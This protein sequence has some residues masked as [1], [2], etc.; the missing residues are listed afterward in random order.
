MYGLVK[1]AA[2]KND[3][4]KQ[5]QEN[6]DDR[7]RA[8]GYVYNAKQNDGYKRN[9]QL[10]GSLGGLAGGAVATPFIAK[11]VN[12]N[13][14]ELVALA[15]MAGFSSGYG[16]GTLFGNATFKKRNQELYDNL[17]QAKRQEFEAGEHIPPMKDLM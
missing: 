7:L 13:L 12:P 10:L 8:Q 2:S 1:L 9:A 11:K 15:P 6:L 4:Y 16:A 5:Y 14:K 3:P 17:E